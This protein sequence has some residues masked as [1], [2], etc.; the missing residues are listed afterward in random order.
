[1]F[2]AQDPRSLMLIT[3]VIVTTAVVFWRMVIKLLIIGTVMLVLLGFL[4]LLQG[5]H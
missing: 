4:E 1:M 3:L 2:A 5:L